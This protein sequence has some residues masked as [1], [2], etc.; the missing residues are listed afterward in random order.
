MKQPG[1]WRKAEMV[2]LSLESIMIGKDVHDDYGLSDYGWY[3]LINL[4]KIR[5]L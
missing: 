5:T 4:H 1:Y 3:A 2:V